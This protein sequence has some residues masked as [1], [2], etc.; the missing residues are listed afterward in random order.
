LTR[1]TYDGCCRVAIAALRQA[2]RDF[3]IELLLAAHLGLR[4][5]EVAAIQLGDLD[6]R[7]VELVIRG[8]DDR[9]ERLPLPLPSDVGEALVASL[10]NGRPERED[11]VLEDIRA[12]RAG[13]WCRPPRSMSMKRTRS[14]SMCSR[15]SR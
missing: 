3:A 2:G 9:H 7:A 6:W 11:P 15:T 12:V 5:G 8:K 4:F 10:R 1:S 13:E 14:V